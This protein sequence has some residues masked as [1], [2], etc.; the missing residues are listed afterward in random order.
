LFYNPSEG[1]KLLGIQLLG[2]VAIITWVSALSIPIFLTLNK[3]GLFRVP[4]E[5]EIIGLDISE[6]G[7]V[8]EELYSK[9][10]KDFSISSPP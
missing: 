1:I 3:L 10:R 2:T 9:L 7:G 5:I 6:M 4:K 8:N